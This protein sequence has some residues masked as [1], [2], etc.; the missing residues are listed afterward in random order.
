MNTGTHGVQGTVLRFPGAGVLGRYKLHCA[1][2]QIQA[3][4]KSSTNSNH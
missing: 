1:E 2:N 3:L 4:D